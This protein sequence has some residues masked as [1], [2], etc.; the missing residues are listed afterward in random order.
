[1]IINVRKSTQDELDP[2]SW[3]QK[4][5]KGWS[6]QVVVLLK[7]FWTFLPLQQKVNW[8][9]NPDNV[10]VWVL[11][12]SITHDP[13]VWEQRSLC[14][15]EELW[16]GERWWTGNERS[17][18][19]KISIWQWQGSSTILSLPLQTTNDM[20]DWF[21]ALTHWSNLMLNY[22]SDKKMN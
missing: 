11:G 5:W 17:L 16:R 15:S 13:C 10:G 19:H 2:W 4:G 21:L 12:L 9:T 14:Q 22:M 7:I 8:E 6:D 1:M 18:C 20:T 3:C